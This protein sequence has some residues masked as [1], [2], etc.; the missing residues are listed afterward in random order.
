MLP[1][2]QSWRIWTVQ[3]LISQSASHARDG[4]PDDRLGQQPNHMTHPIKTEIS[5]AKT[6]NQPRDEQRLP[7][8]AASEGDSSPNAPV[9]RE[10]GCNCRND[11]A[12]RHRP[13]CVAPEG[14]KKAGGHT[15]GRPKDR[16]AV[17]LAEQK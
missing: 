2:D 5:T 7:R 14:N 15:R 11:G 3:Q 17:R 12:D 16:D 6:L 1:G 8:I 10:V 4:G 9:T 13:S